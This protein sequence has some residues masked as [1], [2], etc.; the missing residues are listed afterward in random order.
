MWVIV[1]LT[2]DAS[3]KVLGNPELFPWVGP[4]EPVLGQV[5]R[6]Q[7]LWWPRGFPGEGPLRTLKGG[8]GLRVSCGPSVMTGS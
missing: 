3:V 1:K 2:K 5:L 6:R 7:S 8:D 4:S